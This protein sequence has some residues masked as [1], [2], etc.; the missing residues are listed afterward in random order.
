[1]GKT[2]ITHLLEGT[3]KGIQSLQISN[4]TI[5]GFVIPRAEIKKAK[6]LEELS[7]SPC[8]YIL[9]EESEAVK[10]K[11]YIGQTDDFLDRIYQHNQNKNFWDKA[12]VFISQAG[13]L[14]KADILYLEY[15]GI[16]YA[17][18]IESYNT[19]ENKQ[20]PKQPKLQR[21]IIDTLNDFFED[22]KFIAEFAGFNIL[23]SNSIRDNKYEIF[24]TKGRKSNAMGV[25]NEN[26]FTVLKGSKIAS[27]VVK[28][29]SWEAKRN[30]IIEAFTEVNDGEVILK[31]DYTFNSPSIAGGFCIGSNNNG[32]LVWKNKEGKSLDEIFR[33]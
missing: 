11:A 30:R 4:K 1:M 9:I 6:E 15:L 12:L 29:F 25:Y 19:E 3:P 32:W 31:S 13:T 21:H 33:K 7:A 2:I 24:Y 22:V 16:N 23:K 18:E 27:T 28:S 10:P 5:M 26:G 17:R 14:N 20:N 8:L